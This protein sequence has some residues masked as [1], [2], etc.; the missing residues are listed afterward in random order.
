M[1]IN[2]ETSHIV[3]K[4]SSL[5]EHTNPNFG[6]SCYKHNH[7]KGFMVEKGAKDSILITQPYM[8]RDHY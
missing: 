5:Q 1:V 3:R 7:F 6:F 2:L 8:P 4:S